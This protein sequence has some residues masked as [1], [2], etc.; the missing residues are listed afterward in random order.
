MTNSVTS[1]QENLSNKVAN[2]ELTDWGFE[3]V[4]L[5]IESMGHNFLSSGHRNLWVQIS[6]GRETISLERVTTD[7]TLTDAWG[8]DE[9]TF[10]GA[11]YESQDEVMKTAFSY[12]LGLDENRK[13]LD[14]FLNS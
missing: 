9:E 4:E 7:M 14:K 3:N 13:K 5:A 2:Q 8:D 1:Y 11:M 12:I 10:E 6:V